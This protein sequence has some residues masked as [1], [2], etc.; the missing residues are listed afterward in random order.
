MP[1]SDRLAFGDF[2]LE[3]SQH[4]VVHRDGT[5]VALTPRLFNALAL[6]VE[7]PGELLDKDFLI[8]ELWPGLVVEENNLSQA[9]FGL[10]RALGD[11]GNRYIQTVP[12]R[13]F[14]FIAPVRALDADAGTGDTA[15]QPSGRAGEPSK[16]RRLVVAAGAA[17]ALFVAAGAVSWQLR[18]RRAEAGR[19]TLAVLPFRALGG[20]ADDELIGIGMADSL[21]E[22]LSL[23]A[24]VVVRSTG[25]ALRFGG[26]QQDPLRAARELDVQWI[27][28]GSIQHQGQRLRATARL[29]RAND[30]SSAWSGNFDEKFGDVFDVQDRIAGQLAQ[31]LA[32]TLRT[33]QRGDHEPP[34]ERGDT[35]N[36]EA[37]QLYL[38]AAWRKQG[39]SLQN[40]ERAIDLLHKALALDPD[41][42]LA[43]T[44]LAW[45]HRFKLWNADGVPTDVFRDANAAVDRALAI[46]P[47]LAQARAGLGFSR[48]WFDYDWAGAEREFRAA[49]AANPSEV[50]A[51]QGLGMLLATQ[52]RVDEGLT[53]VRLAR[54]LDPMSPVINSLEAG[55]LVH[56]GK[57]E[58]AQVRVERVLDL[59]PQLWLGHVA[60]GLLLF[61]QQRQ[62]AGL[63]SFRRAVDLAEDTT[64]AKAMF[65][66]HLAQAGRKEEAAAVLDELVA[67]A[68]KRYVPPT[69]IAA[70]QAA[71]GQRDAALASLERAYEARDNRMMYLKD[72]PLWIGLRGEPRFRQLAA[73]LRVDGYGP[74][75]CT[76]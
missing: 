52:D 59:A 51:H 5:P 63:A 76:V 67:I 75:L 54:E 9:V 31:E 60:Q 49:L 8:G 4:R 29:L 23:I 53:H 12:R 32:P 15:A 42:A 25:S 27:V 21:V 68:R 39:G 69:S 40:I 73:R 34:R 13:G 70:V 17:G 6:F 65:G 36:V 35:R 55:F 41:F 56:Q 45:S 74:G 19:L 2:I 58:L 1:T 20:G 18:P 62:E 33:A 3:K 37:Y 71:I 43:W 11:D 16:R 61:A 50:S 72:D 57:L 66:A 22:R 14:R 26:Q 48:F 7:R 44:Q 30:G 24:G 38:T 46:V 28:D 64:R 47:N 10:R